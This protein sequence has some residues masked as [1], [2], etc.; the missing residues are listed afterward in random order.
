MTIDDH[1]A[2]L[3]RV[4]RGDLVESVHLGHLVAV[5]GDPVLGV[6]DPDAVIF[7]RSALKPVQAVAMVRAGLDLDG[8]LLALA[9]ASHSGEDAHLD[10]VRRILAG[11]GLD[12]SSLDNTPDVPLGESGAAAFRA[13][14][15]APSPIAQN[16]SGKHAA[17]LVTCVVNGWPTDGYRAQE[18][19]LQKAVRTTVADLTGDDPAHVTVD[20]CGAPLFSTTTVGLAR[21]FARIAT[22]GPGTPEGRVATAVRE[23]PWWLG[24]TGRPVTRFVESVAGLVAKDGAEG[25]FAAALPDG[26]ALAVK[27]LDGSARPLPP[28]V[29]TA[30]SRLGAPVDDELGRVDVL[31]H[32]DV[33]GRV[34]PAF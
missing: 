16:C 26:R 31:G 8:A 14:G 15:R 29:A 33:V 19:P 6:G 7:P 9:S 30:L 17:M 34:E 5:D 12:E 1:A 21:A 32:G 13:A 2:P 10:G 20:G 11:A 28:V 3:A 23:H 24:G 22:A 18:H 27:V 4:R 25:V